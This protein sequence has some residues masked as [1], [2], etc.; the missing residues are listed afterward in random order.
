M[1]G[2]T[3][4]YQALMQRLVPALSYQLHATSLTEKECGGINS[5]IR[6]AFLPKMHVNRNLPHAVAYGPIEYVGMELPEAYTLQD[7]LQIPYFIKSLRMNGQMARYFPTTLDNIQLDS[8]F[9]SP[10]MED[11]TLPIDYI[12]KGWIIGLRERIRAVDAGIWIEE[13]W[14]P[15]LQREGDTSIMEV[16]SQLF[17]ITPLQLFKVNEVRKTC[18]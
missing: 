6:R 10:I 16:V 2:Y 5:L 13:A 17:G 14:T 12:D 3:S 15:D 7:Q 11:I 1:V 18:G 9:I 8:G 4:A